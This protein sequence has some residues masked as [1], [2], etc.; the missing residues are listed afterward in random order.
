MCNCCAFCPEC[1]HHD[2]TV[3]RLIERQEAERVTTPDPLASIAESLEKLANPLLIVGGSE[4]E[5]FFR[6]LNNGEVTL[7][8]ESRWEERQKQLLDI[9]G[10]VVASMEYLLG[11]RVVISP[12]EGEQR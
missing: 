7:V 10:E 3:K 4:Q 9:S 12:R 11:Y 2:S 1:R 5:K 8:E 6:S